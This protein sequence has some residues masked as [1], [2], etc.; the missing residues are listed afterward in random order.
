MPHSLRLLHFADA[1]IDV[2][3]YGRRDPET[4]LPVRVMDF[5]RSLDEIVEAAIE[6]KVDLVLFAGDA[7]K[8]RHPTPTIQREWA[9][10]ILRLSKAGIP[11]VLLVG[12]HD[13]S[14]S[15]GRAHTLEL[16]RV[17]DVPNIHV[18]D[19]L[20]TLTPET[21]G[22]PL[23]LIA[24]P[25]VHRSALMARGLSLTDPR[26]WQEE[27]HRLLYRFVE[28]ALAQKP[29]GVPAVLLAHAMVPGAQVGWEKFMSLDFTFTLPGSLVR[30]PRLHYVALGH[31]HKQQDLNP[32]GHPPVWYA[33]SIERVSFDEAKEEKGFLLVEISSEGTRVTPRFFQH[34]RPFRTFYVRISEDEPDPTARVLETLGPEENL[35]GAVVRLVVELPREK[36]KAL[37]ERRVYR[38]TRAA[39]EFHLTKRLQD[40][41]RLRLPPD[42]PVAQ[43]SPLELLELYWQSKGRSPEE[44]APLQK[45][46]REIIRQVEGQETEPTQ[47]DEP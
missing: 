34:L 37:D 36:E 46:A 33:G 45:L 29:N 11:T 20:Q 41:Q 18:V 24:I 15:W 27:I 16:F 10:R 12:N 7:F 9:R 2:A 1:H 35:E 30:D 28:D 17:F 43:Y 39:L 5:L 22:L 23:Y 13:L 26:A 4:G 14:P 3:N 25:W 19:R 38:H 31:V 6:E 47:T 40:P 32:G 42:V 44:Y 21:L 8:D